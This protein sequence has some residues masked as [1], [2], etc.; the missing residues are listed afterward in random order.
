VKQLIPGHFVAIFGGAVAGS[1]A[2]DKL[3]Q[4]GI[5]CAV[6]EQNNLPYGKIE[7]GLPKWH[8]KLRDS[9]ERKIDQKLRHPLVDFI[10]NIK[11]GQDLQF[12]DIARN[13]GF[14]A[15]LLATG[16]WR[17]R[18]LP[19][20]GIDKYIDNGL[21][22]QNPF[23][24]WFNQ[25]HDPEYIG[26]QFEI[27]DNTIIIGG[28]LASFDVVKILII[29]QIHHALE[30]KN[31]TSDILTIEKIG[32]AKVLEEAGLTFNELSIEGCSL[33]YRRTITDMPLTS[34]PDNPTQHDIE[35]AHR[36]RQRIFDN[37]QSKYL[38]KFKECHMPV[39]TVTRKGKLDGLVFRK[40]KIADGKVTEIA[41]SEY[42]VPAPLVISAIGSLPESIDG[43]PMNG[44]VYDVT[45]Q[46]SGK[47][48]GYKTV[49]ALGN[50]VTGRG[51]IKE[52]QVH[53]RKVSERVMDEFLAW[54]E[55]D[56]EQIFKRAEE[57]ADLKIETISQLLKE[58]DV[59]DINQMKQ[60]HTKISQLQKQV[61]YKGDYDNWINEHIPVRLEHLIG[62]QD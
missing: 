32:V 49:F 52:S 8:I 48:N 60:L 62:Y 35:T 38:F 5:R 33:Y 19:V 46:D 53:G 51:N 10:P 34:L 20:K 12:D 13:W 25:K 11:L 58:K 50:A 1:E 45:D 15:V 59:L 61:G 23:V 18:P 22:Y 17:D 41:G 29:E 31:I 16:A 6:F 54:R 9:Q 3:T 43:V 57:N 42:E 56:Y 40:T 2:A 36:V 30:R 21:C 39:D 55:E 28:G 7:T 14:S 4:R 24:A 37:M 47:I 44:N 26:P 27:P